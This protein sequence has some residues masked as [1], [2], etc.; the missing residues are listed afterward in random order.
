MRAIRAVCPDWIEQEGGKEGDRARTEQQMAL[1]KC[2]RGAYSPRLLQR[3]RRGWE[4][5]EVA[6]TCAPTVWAPVRPVVYPT[7]LWRATHA[8]G[9][10]RQ[11][12]LGDLVED[13]S[14]LVGLYDDAALGHGGN[15]LRPPARAYAHRQKTGA[16]IKACGLTRYPS[17]Q[18]VDGLRGSATSHLTG[19]WPT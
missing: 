13:V 11:D 4:G 19:I 2:G 8:L 16:K 3:G 14:A 18:M 17:V 9:R 1:V 12:E 6:A 10:T 15:H 7:S 5:R